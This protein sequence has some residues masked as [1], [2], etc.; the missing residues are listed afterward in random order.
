[1]PEQGYKHQ[2]QEFPVG[3]AQRVEPA[4]VGLGGNWTG[5]C[6]R[7]TFFFLTVVVSDHNRYA[8]KFWYNEKEWGIRRHGHKPGDGFGEAGDLGMVVDVHL[9]TC[10]FCHIAV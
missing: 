2:S 3:S 5:A 1:M 8:Y 4:I 10:R 9:N 7:E 6:A